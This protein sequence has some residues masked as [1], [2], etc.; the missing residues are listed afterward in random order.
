MAEFDAWLHLL[1]IFAALPATYM[2]FKV[3]WTQ[4]SV[5]ESLYGIALLSL[6]VSRSVDAYQL[7]TPYTNLIIEWSDL[8]GLVFILSGLFM[9][10]RLG[11]P[12]YTR[13]PLILIFLPMIVLIFYPMILDAEVIKSMLILTFAGGC[14]LVALM[15][16]FTRHYVHQKQFIL[17]SGVV[18]LAISYL[19]HIGF[20]TTADAGWIIFREL[21]LAFGMITTS[22]GIL[23]L[24]KKSIPT[25]NEI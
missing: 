2:I 20:K 5:T 9:N 22:F 6:I 15:I 19:L 7:F 21:F 12:N 23:T 1:V 25:K 3:S 14:V 11:K 17:V 18:M 10:I 8:T 4:K 24:S 16:T 13:Y